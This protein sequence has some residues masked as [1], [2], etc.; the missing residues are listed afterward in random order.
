M[1]Y[2]ARDCLLIFLI[3][4]LHRLKGHFSRVVHQGQSFYNKL[5]P[6][7]IPGLVLHLPAG[8]QN[9]Y[10]LD[11]IG[12]V[13]TSNLRVAPSVPKTSRIPQ[14]S[15]FEFRPRYPLLGG[16]NFSFTLGWDSPLADSGSYDKSTGKYMVEVPIFTPIP[17]AVIS[18]AEVT[19][20]LP[21]GATYVHSRIMSGVGLIHLDRDIEFATPFKAL[22]NWLSTRVT[23]L[24]SIGRPTLA[25]EYKDL[26]DKHAQSI[27]VRP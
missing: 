20:V 11:Q 8:I 14:Y 6:H 19:I 3:L 23:Y 4:C 1:R 15:V 10:Y 18:N 24:D 16:W 2:A 7:V 22:S 17:G 27:L 25:F 26:T 13:S 9:T 21:E 12:N 5:A